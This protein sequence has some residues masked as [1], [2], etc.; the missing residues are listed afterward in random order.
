MRVKRFEVLTR[1]MSSLDGVVGMFARRPLLFFGC[2]IA[3]F[4]LSCVLVIRDNSMWLDEYVSQWISDPSVGFHTAFFERILP[5][6]S[7]PL[8]YSLLRLVRWTGLEFNVSF[9]ILNALCIVFACAFVL[10]MGS[11]LRV[12]LESVFCVAL[13]ALS[14]FAIRYFAEGRTYLIGM[15]IIFC[16]S[17]LVLK[18]VHTG[19]RPAIVA[20]CGLGFV[21]ALTHTFAALAHCAILGSALLHTFKKDDRAL[22]PCYGAMA[23]S[24]L[25]PTFVLVFLNPDEVKAGTTW[26]AFDFP[27]VIS[28]SWQLLNVGIG[29]LVTLVLLLCYFVEA[30]RWHSLSV[31]FRVALVG[32]AMLVAFA[33]LASFIKPMF[34]ARY[35][36]LG[37]PILVVGIGFEATQ[38]VRANRPSCI[39]FAVIAMIASGTPTA[40]ADV[41]RKAKFRGLPLVSALTKNFCPPRSIRTQL[42]FMPRFLSVASGLPANVF[43]LPSE[44]DRELSARPGCPVIGWVE[45]SWLRDEAA[46]NALLLEGLKIDPKTSGIAVVQLGPSSVVVLDNRK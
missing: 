6:V 34:V 28:N 3:L 44:G 42:D 7:P 5:N 17:W 1:D 23:A 9:T 45:H 20:I 13:F 35:L 38:K 37:A 18:A 31:C 2:I 40:Y 27:A 19:E 39:L 32:A 21:A 10:Y 26:I 8:Y 4:G 16:V 33:F 25:V 24:A 11:D 22:L 14:P 36:L 30:G 46:L 43:Y 15:C 41:L 12:R 29:G